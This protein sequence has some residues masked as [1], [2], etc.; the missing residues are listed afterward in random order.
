MVSIRRA[1][2]V[3]I[4][5]GKM[6]EISNEKGIL[7]NKIAEMDGKIVVLQKQFDELERVKQVFHF[8]DLNSLKLR[9]GVPTPYFRFF[10]PKR[11]HTIFS[12]VYVLI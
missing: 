1:A 8:L 2:Q 4:L 12:P 3:E 6:K 5:N 10:P 11:A 9:A 7:S